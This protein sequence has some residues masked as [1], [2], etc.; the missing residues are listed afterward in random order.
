MA[1]IDFGGALAAQLG[2]AFKEKLGAELSP[3]ALQLIADEWQKSYA[4]V[5]L[6]RVIKEHGEVTASNYALD[7]QVDS[8]EA[9]ILQYGAQLR[10]EI[11]RSQTIQRQLVEQGTVNEE[12]RQQIDPNRPSRLLIKRKKK[13]ADGPDTDKPV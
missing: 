1:K 5:F 12:L 8:N 4:S 13:A 9:R 10:E 6:S 11:T 3:P 7:I 2:Q